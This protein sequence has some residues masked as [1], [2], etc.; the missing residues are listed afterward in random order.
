MRKAFSI[1]IW[2]LVA[3][4]G[5]TAFGWIALSRGEPLNAAWLLTA[6]VCTVCGNDEPSEFMTESELE[7]QRG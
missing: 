6:A 5:A 1:L 2:V 4:A 3:I 7:E